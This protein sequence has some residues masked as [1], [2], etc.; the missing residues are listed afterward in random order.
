MSESLLV[1]WREVAEELR[2]GEKAANHRKAY[3]L[4][5]GLI[6]YRVLRLPG[7]KRPRRRVCSYSSLIKAHLI[8]NG[9]L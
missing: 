6:F 4:E 1:G 8:R 3:L 5:C 2:I 7:E 9:Y